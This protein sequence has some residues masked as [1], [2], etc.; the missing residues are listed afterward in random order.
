M[1]V[2]KRVKGGA[3]LLDEKVPEWYNKVNLDSL[4][5]NSYT[6]CVLGQ[7]F[8]GMSYF[9][10][11]WPKLGIEGDEMEE[12]LGFALPVIRRDSEVNKL[13]GNLTQEWTKVILERGAHGCA[14]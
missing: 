8:P 1:S 14:K 12:E 4:N 11:V 10:E 6:N 3:A 13:Y 7:C 5:M 9:E 2:S